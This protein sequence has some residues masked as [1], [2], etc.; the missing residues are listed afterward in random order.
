MSWHADPAVAMSKGKATKT[1]KVAW[2]NNYTKPSVDFEYRTPYD[3]VKTGEKKFY[4]SKK[5]QK[6]DGN[7]N[8]NELVFGVRCVKGK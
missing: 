4:R 1:K 7:K 6:D 5:E 8:E 3:N 2:T